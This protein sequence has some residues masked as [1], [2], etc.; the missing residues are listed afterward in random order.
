MPKPSPHT[1]ASAPGNGVGHGFEQVGQIELHGRQDTFRRWTTGSAPSWRRCS[2]RRWR[3]AG[4]R[5]HRSPV[6]EDSWIV[7]TSR[8]FS[9]ELAR[10]GWL[11][12]TWPTSVGGGGRSPL[13]R[14]VVFEA[15]ISTGA[16]GG[17]VLVRRSPDRAHA[18]AVR[19]RGPA[20]AVPARHHRRHLVVVDRHER[21][22]RRQRRGRHPHPGRARRRRLDRHR[23]QDLDQRRPRCRLVLPDRPHRS[24]RPTPCRP[25]RADRRPA[26]PGRVHLAHHRHDRQPPLL[27][28]GLRRRAGAGGQPGGRA[29]RQLPPGHAPDG[30]RARRHRPPGLQPGAVRGRAAAGRRH[31]SAGSPGAGPAR[32]RLPDRSTPGAARGAWA[33]P[34]P[35]SRR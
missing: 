30:T 22:R 18:H 6:R 10:R 2:A 32:D 7:G 8:A 29:Q 3:S 9:L 12:M 28:G 14:F 16:P 13:E 21:A 25:V 26:R 31:R 17:H 4:R 20:G 15:L 35:G 23:H 19:H 27:R 5:R 24:R 1:R 11:G 33:R 34:R